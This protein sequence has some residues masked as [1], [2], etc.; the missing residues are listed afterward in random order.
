MAFVFDNVLK[1]TQYIARS[2]KRLM[3]SSV[4]RRQR[5]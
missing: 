5:H 2:E 3:A 4:S 1:K